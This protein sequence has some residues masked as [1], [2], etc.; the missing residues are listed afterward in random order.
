MYT[1]FDDCVTVNKKWSKM[2]GLI[3]RGLETPGGYSALFGGKF[4]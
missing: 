3:V 2:L 1:R 4:R